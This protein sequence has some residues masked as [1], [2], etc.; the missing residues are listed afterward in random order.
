MNPKIF[1]DMIK[2]AT[3]GKGGE[4]ELPTP[5]GLYD[6]ILNGINRTGR[7]LLLI[8]AMA[9][10]WWGISDPEYFIV[11]MKA[12]SETPEFI[13]SAILMVIGIF[14]AGRVVGDFKKRA[15]VKQ[16]ISTT[17]EKEVDSE[18]A[19]TMLNEGRFNNLND[20][21]PETSEAGEDITAM[22]PENSAI[23]AWKKKK[24]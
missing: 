6:R 24:K 7:P 9:F 15:T 20:N 16:T 17:V 11:V 3:G 19:D 23:D 22:E 5:T 21:D 1:L 4:V 12:F 10:F 14:G 18:T 8:A 2:N 13:A